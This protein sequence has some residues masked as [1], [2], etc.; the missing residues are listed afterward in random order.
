VKTQ[1]LDGGHEN[2]KAQGLK[3]IKQD[4]TIVIFELRVDCELILEK[5]RDSLAKLT[6]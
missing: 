5:A 6:G 1:D 3:S 2:W 4:L